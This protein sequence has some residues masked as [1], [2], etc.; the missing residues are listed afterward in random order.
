MIYLHPAS[1]LQA[2][3]SYWHTSFAI[4]NNPR[5]SVARSKI[6]GKWAMDNDCFAAWDANRF[7]KALEYHKGLPECLFVVCPDV[8][9]NAAQTLHRWH[10]WHSVIRE[11]GYPVAFVAQNGLR[12]EDVPFDDMQAL[13]IGGD[14]SFKLGAFVAD[15]V[16]EAKRRGCHVHM[17]RVNSLIRLEYANAIGCDSVDGSKIRFEPE[18]I[19]RYPAYLINKQELL[20]S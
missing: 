4:L 7:M 15:V 2:S 9:G 6:V 1:P 11:Y 18:F 13:F 10:I 20:W 12:L 3:R 17:G 5:I 14:N 19:K 16:K 8:V